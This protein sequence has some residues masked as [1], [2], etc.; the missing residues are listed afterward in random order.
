MY[1]SP[2]DEQPAASGS[3]SFRHLSLNPIHS[4]GIQ[5]N[6]Q[7][8][9]MMFT[10]PRRAEDVLI[11]GRAPAI[12]V[13][14]ASSSSLGH[15]TLGRSGA[16]HGLLPSPSSS[17][18]SS[19]SNPSDGWHTRCVLGVSLSDIPP[20]YS[21]LCVRQDIT[22]PAWGGQMLNNLTKRHA[23]QRHVDCSRSNGGS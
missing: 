13:N 19:L 14:L 16:L 1:G 4:A 3:R 7:S 5:H 21:L 6:R 9:H 11:W 10:L 17:S 20:R 8:C 12:S 15:A 23:L 22:P 2:P 18:S